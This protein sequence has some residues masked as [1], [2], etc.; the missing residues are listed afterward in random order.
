MKKLLVACFIA[1]AINASAQEANSY[2][3]ILQQ[4]NE[5][6]LNDSLYINRLGEEMGAIDSATAQKW[7][8]PVFTSSQTGKLKKRDFY[9]AGKITTNEYFDLLLLVEEKKKADSTSM[10]VLYLVTVK[11]D[12]NYIASF[13]AAIWGQSKKVSYNVSSWLYKGLKIVQDSRISTTQDSFDDLTEYVITG[14]GRFIA[15]AKN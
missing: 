9:I 5:I 11:K 13:K 4:T 1:L 2:P 12:G 15:F 8:A 10:Q 14:K 6:S 7:F 3:E